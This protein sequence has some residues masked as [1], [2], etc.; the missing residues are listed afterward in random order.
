MGRGTKLVR[1]KVRVCGFLLLLLSCPVLVAQSTG[2]S[3]QEK[4][5]EYRGKIL[6]LNFW[7]AWCQP[8]TRELPLLVELQRQ[9]EARGVQFVGAC[10]DDSK[11]REKAEDFLRK[12]VV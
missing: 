3:L 5:Q 11:D 2:S 7:A 4:L 6:V 1:V 10:T 12:N 8:C 9:Y